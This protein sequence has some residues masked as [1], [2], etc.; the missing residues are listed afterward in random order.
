MHLSTLAFQDFSFP[1]FFPELFHPVFA[2]LQLKINSLLDMFDKVI[3]HGGEV[4][5]FSIVDIH[6]VIVGV[7][8]ALDGEVGIVGEEV[9]IPG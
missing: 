9:A 6:L 1:N 5:S 8:V 4:A 7:G 3:P 2:K